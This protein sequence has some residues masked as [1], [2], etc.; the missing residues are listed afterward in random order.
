[1]TDIE[2]EAPIADRLKLRFM[3]EEW[4]HTKSLSLASKI[5]EMLDDNTLLLR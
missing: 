1:M 3:L 2:K 5:C 4:S